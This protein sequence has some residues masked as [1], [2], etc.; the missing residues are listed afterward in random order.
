M[1]SSAYFIG[2]ERKD[3]KT[4]K[5]G[6]DCIFAAERLDEEVIEGY[7]FEH[8]TLAN[9]S[10]LQAKIS[11]SRFVNCVFIGCYFRRAE[12]EE[13]EFLGCKFLNCEFPFTAIR[14]CDFRYSKFSECF[15]E[16]SEISLSLPQEHNLRE[17]LCRNLAIEASR[18]GSYR[19][20]RNYRMG[21]I[22]AHE[23][24]LRAAILG[25]NDWYRRHYDSLRRVGAIIRLSVSISNRYLWGYGEQAWRLLLNYAVIT[26]GLFPLLFYFL[27]SGLERTDRGSVRYSDCVFLSVQNMIPS[28]LISTV[29]AV[30][31]T[32]RSWALI[33]TF[34]GLVIIGLLV[35]YL[36]R[37]IIRA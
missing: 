19:D 20:G 28:S 37:W 35:S 32:A 25:T 11:R 23:D 15:I 18:L 22:R 2:R 36:F 29:H 4:T 13:S 3:F 26:F 34:I 17:E 8:C 5:K 6:V 30:S 12:L 9:I 10:F 14:G 21:E 24:D 33:E 31:T 27:R 7:E 16:F 1:N